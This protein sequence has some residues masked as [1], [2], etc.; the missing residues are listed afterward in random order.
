[1]PFNG[2]IVIAAAGL[3]SRLGQGKPKALVEVDGRTIIDRLLTGCLADE[4][5]IRIVVGYQEQDLIEH[6]RNIRPDV[7]F[8]RNPDYRD[9]ASRR[10]LLLGTQA[11][12][13]PLI[14]LDAD[15]LIDRQSW[16]AFTAEALKRST[17][18][19]SQTDRYLVGIT[20]TNSADAVYVRTAGGTPAAPATVTGFTRKEPQAFEWANIAC[21]DNSCFGANDKSYVYECLE[22][23]LPLATAVIDLA[24]IDTPQDMEAAKKWLA[25]K[26]AA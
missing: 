24:E 8:V 21:L 16:Q 14:I 18:G 23:Y 7:I 4:A 13:Q 19:N 2:P 20:P 22:P 10:S 26:G 25:K 9:G 12:K 5:D 11:I 3:G 17:Q 6:V 1:M 15:L